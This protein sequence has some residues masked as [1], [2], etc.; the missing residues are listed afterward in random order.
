[1]ERRRACRDEVGAVLLGHVCAFVL[2]FRP[3]RGSLRHS[4]VMPTDTARSVRS[5]LHNSASVRFDCST[6]VPQR[7]AVS[8]QAADL[9]LP[10]FERADFA[11]AVR[12]C[13]TRSTYE[14]LTSNSAATLRADRPDR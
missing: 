4:A 14:T 11:R 9:H 8:C 2:S 7:L 6:T 3:S 1:M 13:R 12:R 5:H 10:D